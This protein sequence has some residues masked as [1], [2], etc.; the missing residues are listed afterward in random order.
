MTGTWVHVRIVTVTTGCAI[1]ATF[2]S[3]IPI[4]QAESEYPIRINRYG[5]VRDSGGAGKFRGGL[6]VERDWTLLK[7]TAVSLSDPTAATIHHTDCSAA[8]PARRRTAFWR[9]PIAA[10]CCRR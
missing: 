1:S 7:G 2:I 8:V 6:A 9:M 10:K 4:E 5:F 3:N